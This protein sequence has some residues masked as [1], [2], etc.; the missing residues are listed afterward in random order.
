MRYFFLDFF[1]LA[2]LSPKQ[3]KQIDYLLHM[4]LFSLYLEY[5]QLITRF[6]PLTRFCYLST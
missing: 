6:N 2:F 3:C 4:M 5:A 1:F